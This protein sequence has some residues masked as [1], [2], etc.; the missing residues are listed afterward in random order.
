MRGDGVGNCASA[1]A[2][3]ATIG[4][5]GIWGA[6]S[7]FAK[8]TV[9]KS[10]P[11]AELAFRVGVVGHRPNRLPH[12]KEKLDALRLALRAVLA[13]AKAALSRYAAGPE[14]QAHYAPSPAILR[15][16]S[17]LAEGSDR[18]FAEEALDL[19]YSL[20]CPL[21]FAQEEYEKDFV[22][23]AALQGAFDRPL[24]QHPAARAG[25][26]RRHDIRARRDAVC[27]G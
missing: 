2:G 17:A 1:Q 18:M 6:C 21:P 25:G 16:V 24:P 11:R 27:A 4:S 15:A 10:P 14:A 5:F 26:R 12:E 13:E 20:C 9:L 8:S 19:G 23:P 3:P 7:V 22:P